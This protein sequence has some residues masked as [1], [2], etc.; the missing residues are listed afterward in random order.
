MPSL[1]AEA[2]GSSL[3]FSFSIAAKEAKTDTTGFELSPSGFEN[4]GAAAGLIGSVASS[5]FDFNKSA[6]D[7]LGP[8]E[9]ENPLDAPLNALNPPVVGAFVGVALGDWAGANTDFAPPR[10]EVE[11][12]AGLAVVLTG[13][14]GVMVVIWP[15][16]ETGGGFSSGFLKNAEVLGVSLLP[17]APNPAAGLKAEGVACILPNAPLLG[18]GAGEEVCLNCEGEEV[19][20]NGEGDF[21]SLFPNGDG[22][23]PSCFS[24]AGAAAGFDSGELGGEGEVSNDGPL[25]EAIGLS[26][27]LGRDDLIVDVPKRAEEPPAAGVVGVP[28]TVVLGLGSAAGVEL[29]DEEE[30]AAG[31]L[32]VTGAPNAEVADAKPPKPPPEEEGGF[33]VVSL[34]A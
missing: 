19:C 1:E 13:V 32:G 15:K 18:A 7:V 2:L 27:P 34:A 33:C 25:G 26:S 30:S 21:A 24:N 16:A 8:A 28:K 22:D 5:L 12:N 14:L 23:F 31:A 11:P 10:A 20:P 6:N 29:T 4:T 9:A 3:P 17:N